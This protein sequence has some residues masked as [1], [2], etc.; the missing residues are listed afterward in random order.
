MRPE[1]DELNVSRCQCPNCPT[2]DDC[3]SDRGQRIYCSR[4]KT[5]CT[6]TPKGCICPECQV[7]LDNDLSERYYCAN[8]AA[9][10]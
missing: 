3:M 7:W 9:E 4:G 2:Y 1:D 8:G 6:P 10:G 5:D